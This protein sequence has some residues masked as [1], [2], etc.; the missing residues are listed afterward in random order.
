MRGLARRAPG[1]RQRPA[2]HVVWSRA[3][4]MA[5]AITW[6][7][8]MTADRALAQSPAPTPMRGM[9][10]RGGSPATMAGD[11]V[12]A[13]IAVVGLGILAAAATALFV[14]VSRWMRHDDGLPRSDGE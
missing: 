12:L 14:L 1:T 6:A 7:L 3:V 4:R 9:D 10:P 2:L 13:A 8:L 5:V 11:P